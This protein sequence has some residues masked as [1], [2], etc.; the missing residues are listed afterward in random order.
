MSLQIPDM[1]FSVQAKDV[2]GISGNSSKIVPNL[3]ILN[4]PSLGFHSSAPLL[5]LDVAV[6]ECCPC[7]ADVPKL[8]LWWHH[9]CDHSLTLTTPDTLS[10]S[11]LSI[12]ETS[13]GRET[14]LQRRSDNK[15]AHHFVPCIQHSIVSSP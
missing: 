4:K 13:P 14:N 12:G 10:Q 8:S 15:V 7:E 3:K 9:H 2:H 1:I 11:P 6:T 5:A